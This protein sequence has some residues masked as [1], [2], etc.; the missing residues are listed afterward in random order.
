[1]ESKNMFKAYETPIVEVIEVQVERGFASSTD[2]YP[3]T[4]KEFEW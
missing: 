3:N 2:N 1:M 4:D